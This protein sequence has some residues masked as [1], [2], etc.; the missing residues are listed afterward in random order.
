MSG[1]EGLADLLGVHRQNLGFSVLP[2]VR[3]GAKLA[4]RKGAP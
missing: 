3:C 4:T 1:L 2:M